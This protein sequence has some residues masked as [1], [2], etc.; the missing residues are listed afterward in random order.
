LSNFTTVESWEGSQ[1][2][3]SLPGKAVL[4]FERKESKEREAVNNLHVQEV[5]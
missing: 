2:N 3:K 5:M 4:S 1:H